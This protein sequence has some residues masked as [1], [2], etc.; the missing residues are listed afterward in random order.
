[1]NSSSQLQS[2]R[3][4]VLQNITTQQEIIIKKKLVLHKAYMVAPNS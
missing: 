1:M 4:K 2:P 3:R